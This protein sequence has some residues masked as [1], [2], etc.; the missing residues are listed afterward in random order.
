[1]SQAS[2]SSRLRSIVFKV[3]LLLLLLLPVGL[4]AYKLYV[5]DYPIKDLMPVTSYQ[6]ELAI[7]L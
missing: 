6:V 3:V 5:L 7:Q 4:M 2:H 1:M